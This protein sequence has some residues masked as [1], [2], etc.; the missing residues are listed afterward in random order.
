MSLKGTHTLFSQLPKE[1]REVFRV[2][3][4]DRAYLG[5]L[6]DPSQIVTAKLGEGTFFVVGSLSCAASHSEPRVD[7]QR[8]FIS[9]VPGNEDEIQEFDQDRRP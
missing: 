4:K 5:S 8:L 1:L 9:I 6:L 2:H 7:S 3:A